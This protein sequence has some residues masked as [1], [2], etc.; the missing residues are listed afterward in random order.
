[1]DGTVYVG[2]QRTSSDV[3][4]GSVHAVWPDGTNRWV[5]YISGEVYASPALGAD[6]TV[7][8]STEDG[9]V[10]ALDSDGNEKW[11]ALL[12]VAMNS[13]PA[14]GPDGRMYVGCENGRLYCFGAAL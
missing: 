1:V 10:Y 5:T 4:M 13:S 3:T 7:Y 2:V 8:I 12:G 11:S 14:I 9:L 6:G